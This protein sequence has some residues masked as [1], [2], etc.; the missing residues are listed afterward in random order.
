MPDE[1]DLIVDTFRNQKAIEDFSVAVSYD[2]IK[3]KNYS[4][5]AGQYFDVKIEYVD[6]TSE[7]FSQ[8]IEDARQLLVSKFEDSREL[9]KR[10]LK[11]LNE[12]SL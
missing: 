7:Q 12:L 2:D 5:S 6:I 10:I 4:L 9:E 1:I 11:Q 8:N 3:E